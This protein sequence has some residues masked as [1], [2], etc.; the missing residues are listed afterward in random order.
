MPYTHYNTDER[1]VLQAMA[2]M[3]LPKCYMSVILGKHLSS[4]YRE[5]N[6]N[7]L[8][9]V[10][11][12]NEAQPSSEQR[13]LDNKPS[14]RMDDHALMREITALFKQDLSPDQISSRLRV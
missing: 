3:H 1:N 12:G 13:R 6:R 9:G 7:G 14:P 8:G 10:Y 11:T 2:G 4:I 5:L